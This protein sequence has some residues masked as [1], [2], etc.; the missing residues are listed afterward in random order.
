MHSALIQGLSKDQADRARQSEEI[1][2]EYRRLLASALTKQIEGA[3]ND[4]LTNARNVSAS[5]NER[6]EKGIYL[7]ALIDSYHNLLTF[8]K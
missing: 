8:I 5:T 7:A 2:T 4:L 1:A 3:K 6:A